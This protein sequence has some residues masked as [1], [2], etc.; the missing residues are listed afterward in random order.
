VAGINLAIAEVR[1]GML[2]TLRE[3]PEDGLS[4]RLTAW[5]DGN[6]LVRNVFIWE[7]GTGLV[8]PDPRQPVSDEERAFVAR[9]QGLFAERIPWV[10]PAGERPAPVE[11]VSSRYALRQLSKV[12]ASSPAVEDSSTSL[13]SGGWRPWF[14]ENRLYQL[15][16]CES[17]DG[18]LRYGVEL[19]LMALLA[20]LVETL[21]ADAAPGETYALL[22]DGGAV[23]LQRGA[24]EITATT[25]PILALPVGTALPH[26]QI[27][28]YAR[29]ED[30]GKRSIVLFGT[31]LVA[32]FVVAILGGGGLLLW[33][34]RRQAREALRK[35][36]F[37]A[38]VSHE[39]KTPL[40]TIRMYAELLGE[41]DDAPERRRR[42]LE[43]IGGECQRLSRLVNN[44]LDFSRLEQ[45]RKQYRPEPLE[46]QPFLSQLFASQAE[47]LVTAGVSGHLLLPPDPVLV[48]SDRDALEQVL[49][50]LIDN[51]LKYAASGKELTLE[52]LPPQGANV[53][54]RLLDRGPGI[55]AP[56]REKIFDKFHR[57]DDA[58][59]ARQPGCGLGLAISRQLL[60][61]LGGELRWQPRSG[62]GSCFEVVLPQ[63]E[64]LP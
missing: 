1:E 14:W 22:D 39:L 11:A 7:R 35:T 31:L 55:P 17:R 49:L 58:L 3:L 15:G 28:V 59:T 42:Y 18:R 27:A 32:I 9:Y 29:P 50:N 48:R 44:V 43:V 4:Q 12:A 40:T 34:G 61:D 53:R 41:A 56:H 19:E 6:P 30:A 37:V 25:A 62:G 10:E 46:L 64:I 2:A 52:V 36:S 20:R 13:P 16:W 5:R 54:L 8:L 33:E 24:M 60:R 45:G 51:A 57:V 26:W 23:F 63:M 38:N 21:P 47:R